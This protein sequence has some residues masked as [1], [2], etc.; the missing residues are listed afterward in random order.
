MKI[1]LINVLVFFGLTKVYA[2]THSSFV[3]EV[4]KLEAAEGAANGCG[5]CGGTASIGN[6]NGGGR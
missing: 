4:I 2:N 1:L 6:G 5:E 3:E